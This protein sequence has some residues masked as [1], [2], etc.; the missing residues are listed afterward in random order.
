M[1]DKNW[2]E[3]ITDLNRKGYKRHGWINPIEPRPEASDWKKHHYS[4][5]SC[6][7]IY[8][9]ESLRMFVVIDSSD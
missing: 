7:T 5:M 2:V 8:V 1:A 9:S 3:V 6:I 4:W